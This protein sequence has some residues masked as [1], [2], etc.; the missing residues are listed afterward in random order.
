MLGGV[1][2]SFKPIIPS[3]FGPLSIAQQRTLGHA[4]SSCAK[5]CS[6]AESLFYFDEERKLILEGKIG[7]ASDVV[8]VRRDLVASKVIA[9]STKVGEACVC[10]VA[11]YVDDHLKDDLSDPTR[12]ILLECEW[13]LETP[14]SKVCCT[15]SE[16]YSICKAGGERNMF[17]EVPGNGFFRN[18]LGDLVLNG[19]IGVGKSKEANGKMMHHLRFI[20]DLTP[21]NTYMRKLSGD[22]FLCHRP[23]IL[24]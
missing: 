10:A 11:E 6:V 16:W 22:C 2:W 14:R 9:A 23:G 15:D 8:S 1:G 4:F 20:S 19:A 7:Y 13:P 12:C 17:T 21:A 24:I 5:L 18:Q 3:T